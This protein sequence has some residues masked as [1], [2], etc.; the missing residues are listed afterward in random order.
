MEKSCR[1]CIIGRS[2][3]CVCAE[4][5]IEIMS[6]QRDGMF[7]NINKAIENQLDA[8]GKDCELYKDYTKYDK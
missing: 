3:L 4:S 5:I 7:V 8:L 1:T 2:N 6:T